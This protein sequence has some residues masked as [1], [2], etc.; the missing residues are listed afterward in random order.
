M[1]IV[2]VDFDLLGDFF[3]NRYQHVVVVLTA[4]TDI[5]F[6]Y[7]NFRLFPDFDKKNASSLGPDWL[8]N[9]RVLRS[10]GEW[11]FKTAPVAPGGVAWRNPRPV[12]VLAW[13]AVVRAT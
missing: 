7:S 10:P 8:G 3:R 9:W 6:E 11:G 13:C 5:K 2:A 12:G 1:V 4:S